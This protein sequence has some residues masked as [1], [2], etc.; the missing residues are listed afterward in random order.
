M[1]NYWGVNEMRF[2]KIAAL[3]FCVLLLMVDVG[4]ASATTYYDNFTNGLSPAG[5][6]GSTSYWNIMSVS[7]ADVYNV[8][9][10]GDTSS[11]ATLWPLGASWIYTADY[12]VTQ[13]YN[14][15]RLVNV[16]LAANGNGEMMLADVEYA[17]DSKQSLMTLQY[18]TTTGNWV[19]VA[20]PYGWFSNTSPNGTI[21]L[22][23]EPGSSKIIF[24][25]TCDNG[26]SYSATSGAIPSTF[27]SY[28]I[29][30]G[31]RIYE[32]V[33]NWKDAML[34]TPATPYGTL[35][36]NVDLKNYVGDY[37]LANLEVY[38]LSTD[39]TTTIST[40]T[41]T[42]K[43]ENSTVV[44]HGVPVG[45]Y[46]IRASSAKWLSESGNASITA[47]TTSTISL[48]LPNGDLNGD[49]AIEDQDYSIMGANWY[50]GGT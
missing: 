45:T 35:N 26:F 47:N 7:S 33:V 24:S 12:S 38:V 50:Q 34:V 22:D 1:A 32:G 13:G 31:F 36:V 19:T 17:T 40:Q 30:P 37:T 15:G 39:G 46:L 48:V 42:P 28:L 8:N 41:I 23:L 29:N 20:G 9:Y 3:A 16:D 49:G 43:T 4:S 10:N 11:Y 25:L 5:W 27:L 21:K 44:F 18:L 6:N 14:S 2:F